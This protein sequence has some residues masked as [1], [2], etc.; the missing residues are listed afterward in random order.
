MK[1]AIEV[2]V[3]DLAAVVGQSGRRRPS[4]VDPGPLAPQELGVTQ[5]PLPQLVQ[6]CPITPGGAG[7]SG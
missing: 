1:A 7:G 6:V 4:G 5:D 2:P 3:V